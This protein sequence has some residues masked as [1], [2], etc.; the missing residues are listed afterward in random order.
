MAL[1]LRRM[2]CNLHGICRDS[3]EAV[4]VMSNGRFAHTISPDHACSDRPNLFACPKSN[5]R[6]LICT[7]CRKSMYV[8]IDPITLLALDRILPRLFQKCVPLQQASWK[9]TC[10]QFPVAPSVG[11][12]ERPYSPVLENS[13]NLFISLLLL[14]DRLTNSH[15]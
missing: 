2:T 10:N 6:L 12:T 11:V 3:G 14:I 9:R 15:R 8:L 7:Q 5:L 1:T 4:R 13:R